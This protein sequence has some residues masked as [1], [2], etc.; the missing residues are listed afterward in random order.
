MKNVLKYLV[1]I[2]L[3]VI[4]VFMF[5]YFRS[6]L[7]YIAIAGILSLFAKPLF[8]LF[9]KVRYKRFYI[10]NGVSAFFSVVILWMLLIAFFRFTI[11]L[12]GSELHYL[13]TVDIP[14]VIDRVS[15][16]LFEAL[17]P[18]RQ[19][20]PDIVEAIETQVKEAAST[21]FNV[22]YLRETFSNL[23]GFVGGFFVAAFSITFLTFFF[24]KE[25]GLLVSLILIIIPDQFEQGLRHVL[26][27]IRH[28]LRRYF[29]G[30]VLQTFLITLLITSGFLLIG[31]DFNQ[32]VTIGFISG[33]LNLIPYVG[34]II[35]AFFGSITGLII[36]LQQ[37][38]DM[39]L[40]NYLG[41]IIA[42]YGIVQL[43]DNILFQPIIFS[44]SVKAHPVEI[45]LVIMMAGYIGG[46]VGMFLAIPVYT[47]IRVVAREFFY[48][49]RVVKKI[50]DGFRKEEVL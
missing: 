40:L 35:G 18:I 20:N 22:M 14:Q 38:F 15:L 46:L 47:I 8:D 39:S 6:I 24:L 21:V 25:E 30:V 34:P 3:V 45:F 5:W 37:P 49:Y 17:E 19:I 23:I 26:L 44:N 29:F 9:K 32:A 7:F 16:M 50:T 36:Y 1:I 12:V 28:L 31:V 10:S 43:I 13:S 42:V 11:P 48:N 33:L 2:S 41:F 4:G 27:S